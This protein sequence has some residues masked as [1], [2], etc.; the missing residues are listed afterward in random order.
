[1]F[2]CR[3]VLANG[4]SLLCVSY[5]KSFAERDANKRYHTSLPCSVGT[6]GCGRRVLVVLVNRRTSVHVGS[7]HA[8][9]DG[10]GAATVLGGRPQTGAVLVGVRE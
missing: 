4:A 10:V 8:R 5:N 6:A 9:L 2:F 3:L 7:E 1:M